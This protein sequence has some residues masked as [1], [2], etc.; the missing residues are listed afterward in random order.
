MISR[1]VDARGL[2]E[3]LERSRGP[4][5]V[6]LAFDADGTLW[7][8]DVGEDVFEYAT[9]NELLT[10]DPLEALSRVA[11]EH[12]LDSHGSSSRVAAS[13]FAGYRRGLVDEK[14][15][16]E[17][18]TWAYAG[19]TPDELGGIASRAFDERDLRSRVRHL[20]DPVFEWA[21]T[22]RARV[23]VISASPHTVIEAA[24]LRTEI[25]VESILAGHASL[26][27]GRFLPKMD[28]PLPY[29]HEKRLA[30]ERALSGSTWLATFGDNAFDVEML[31][32]ARVGVAVCP[33]PAL[34]T[35]LSRLPNTV[36]LE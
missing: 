21:R 33:K 15:T 7:S 34:L 5:P 1:R 22:E 11:E 25:G 12:G 24:L 9:A 27:D 16:C 35:R 19:L 2:L 29:G 32:A 4:G 31:S 10:P 13:I 17:V 20:L 8:G 26:A 18:M 14:K 3:L 30:G 6:G 36:V 23:I 28:G